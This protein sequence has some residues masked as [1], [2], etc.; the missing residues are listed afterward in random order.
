MNYK[1]IGKYIKNLNFNIPNP[2]AFFLLSKNI[3]NY[4]INIDI[5]SSQVK[6]KIVEVQT[7]LS[8]SPV[9]DNFEIIDT[10]IL[11]STIIEIKKEITDKKEIEKIILIDVPTQ[12]YPELRNI[13][14]FIFENSGFKEIK[15]NKYVDFEKLYNQKKIQ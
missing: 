14:V 12:I 1:I 7:S 11:F 15:I 5:K 3:S 6:E 2:K 13:F 9:K 8:L 4:K 10:K